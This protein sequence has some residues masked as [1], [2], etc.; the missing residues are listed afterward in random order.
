MTTLNSLIALCG[1]LLMST[2]AV[3][4][5]S[6]LRVTTAFNAKSPRLAL[7]SLLKER[8]AGSEAIR[9]KL[10]HGQGMMRR[11]DGAAFPIEGS[12]T[13]QPLL[14][15]D[16][17]IN[18]GIPA[19]SINLAGLEFL[20]DEDSRAEAGYWFGIRVGS[21][22]TVTIFEGRILSFYG[23]ATGA[24]QLE[25]DYFRFETAFGLC[26]KNYIANWWFLDA[27][28]R[29]IRSQKEL[30]DDESSGL[31]LQITK[32]SDFQFGTFEGRLKAER[33]QKNQQSRM[34]YSIDG[35]ATLGVKG[36]LRVG[37]LTAERYDGISGVVTAASIGFTRPIAGGLTSVDFSYANEEGSSFFGNERSEITRV[38][39]ISRQI[40][41]K[42]DVFGSYE[43][44]RSTIEAFNDDVAVLGVEFAGWSF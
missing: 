36:S 27:C 26:S 38:I 9:L 24:K 21:E 6:V 39:R 23:I 15:F 5:D 37:L 44:V 20:V 13:V 8:A 33:E 40:S 3:A 41:P 2:E 1:A 30:M 4:D 42:I 18:G 7:F 25:G 19:E 43:H 31:S 32:V 14:G 29:S 10:L 34:V 11:S 17:N 12:M 16:G 22:V 28:Y 35:I